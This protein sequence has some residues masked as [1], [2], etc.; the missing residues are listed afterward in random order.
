MERRPPCF[1][2]Y[3]GIADAE[4]VRAYSRIKAGNE[5]GKMGVEKVFDS[6][7]RGTNGLEYVMVNA[8]GESNLR[9]RCRTIANP[10]EQ[11][12]G[13]GKRYTPHH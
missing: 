7:L 4:E 3:T 10:Q 11:G 2:G 8:H 6:E 9:L 5:L 1:L 13:S 12:N